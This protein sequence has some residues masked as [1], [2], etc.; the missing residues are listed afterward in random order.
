MENGQGCRTDNIGNKW[1][2]EWVNGKTEARIQSVFFFYYDLGKNP[3]K[4]ATNPDGTYA[5]T[6][7]Y[8]KSIQEMFETMDIESDS[9]DFSRDVRAWDR[10]LDCWLN[11]GV[12]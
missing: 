9:K 4:R 8:P 7:E 11:S 12:P 1:D 6:N 5:D 3:N 10:T 2:G